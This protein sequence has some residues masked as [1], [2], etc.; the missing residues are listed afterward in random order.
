MIKLSF[1]GSF[2]VVSCHLE[3]LRDRKRLQRRQ[4]S[5]ILLRNV[6]W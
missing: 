1:S 3:C 6:S 5:E 4:N 2:V